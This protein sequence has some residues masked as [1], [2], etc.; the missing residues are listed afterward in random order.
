[1][2]VN[3]VGNITKDYGG[4]KGVFDIGFNVE[5]SE[6]VGFLGPIGAAETETIRQLMGFIHPDK[7]SCRINGLDCFKKSPEIQKSLGYLPGE[8]SFMDDMTGIEFIRFVAN[9]KGMRGLDRAKERL[10]TF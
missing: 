5:N 8:I 2:S 4:G 7:G 10:E 9:M 6:V 1:M 3:E